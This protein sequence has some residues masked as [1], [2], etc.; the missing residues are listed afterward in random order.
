MCSKPR[1]LPSGTGRTQKNRDRPC[2]ERISVV[3]Q[4]IRRTII[5][6]ISKGTH[7]GSCHRSQPDAKPSREKLFVGTLTRKKR[8]ERSFRELG[9]RLHPTLYFSLG[10]SFLLW[11]EERR[12]ITVPCQ[13]YRRLNDTNDPEQIPA[14]TIPELIDKL[15]GAQDFY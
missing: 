6:A 3:C 5:Q 7:L 4:S 10:S 15:K 11:W 2:T 9:Q 8:S 14:T 13:D 12:Q 1:L